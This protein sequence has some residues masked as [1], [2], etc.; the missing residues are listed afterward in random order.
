MRGG[1]EA[2]PR[3]RWGQRLAL[4]ALLGLGV[5]CTRAKETTALQAPITPRA[6]ETPFALLPTFRPTATPMPA[7]PLAPAP[8]PVNP[9]VATLPPG[10]P[11]TALPVPVIPWIVAS[12]PNRV[13]SP[14]VVATSPALSGLLAAQ[15]AAHPRLSTLT[16]LLQRAGLDTTLSSAGPFTLFAPTDQAFAA[17]PPAELGDLQRDENRALLTRILR[18]HVALGSLPRAALTS[19]QLQTAEGW[20]LT[21]QNTAGTPTISGADLVAVDQR[22]SNG[23]LHLVDRV[24]RP[25]DVLPVATSVVALVDARPELSTLR[26]L[27]TES[28]VVATLQTATSHTLFAPTNAA[29]AALPAAGLAALRQPANAA[30]LTFLLQYHVVAGAQR[31][32]NL[33]GRTFPT[34]AVAAPGLPAQTVTIASGAVSNQPIARYDQVASNGVMHVIDGVLLPPGFTLP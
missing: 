30:S 34:L 12:Q 22:A 5:A 8:L 28:G 15:V 17:L 10:D 1:A 27:L 19:P 26:L 31:S 6:T 9:P 7:P 29:F 24:L 13:A 3:A 25:P 11:L 14:T 4:M 23:V 16:G 2:G 32:G 20:M 33:P 21:L 18:Y